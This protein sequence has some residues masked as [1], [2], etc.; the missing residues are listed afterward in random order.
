MNKNER[1]YLNT[2]L[3]RSFVAIADCGSLTLAAG[4]L[5]RTQSAVS[6]QLGKLEADL[7][8]LLFD[9]TSK[10]MVLSDAGVKL[11]PKARSI[12]KDIKQ[13]AM[14]FDTELTGSIRV[15]VPDDFNDT[16]LEQILTEFGVAHPGVDV[17]AISGC[18]SGYGAKVK[19]GDI[20]I[21]VCSGPELDGGETLGTEKTVWAAKKGTSFAQDRPVPLAILDRSCVWRDLPIE[22]LNAIGRDYKISFCSSDFGAL[23]AAIRAGFA[24]GILPI[25]SV[26][27]NM[28]VL[29]KADGFPSLPASRRAI[30]V[31][32]HTR[33]DLA[34][35]MTEA[36]YNATHSRR[37]VN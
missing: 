15:G 12:L 14:L 22:A 24:I 37:P 20:D 19:S 25:S 23:C 3:L 16:L 32:R 34:K 17:E 28:T 21:A 7:G 4:R 8:V 35:A 6:V 2:D 5:F 11:L 26:D 36:I 1:S 18:T 33:D 27:E 9:R 31:G 13:A 10:G 30:L 29:S